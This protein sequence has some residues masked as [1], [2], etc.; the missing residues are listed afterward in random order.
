MVSED[1]ANRINLDGIAN[2][3]TSTVALK[4]AGFVQ[5]QVSMCI[6][7][8]YDSLLLVNTWMANAGASAIPVTASDAKRSSTSGVH[9]ILRID[10]CASYYRTNR[11]T[12]LNGI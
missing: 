5:G 8:P 12:I 3:G 1:S 11:V 9:D 10:C 2:L 6:S 4:V 7:C